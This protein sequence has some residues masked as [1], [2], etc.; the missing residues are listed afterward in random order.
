VVRR[1]NWLIAVAITL[2]ILCTA[3]ASFGAEQDASPTTDRR[4]SK[5]WMPAP[6]VAFNDP[7]GSD[8]G[9]DRLLRRIIEAVRHTHKGQT[10]R[11]AQYSFDRR[12]M[13]D[14]LIRAH[15]RGVNVQIIVND[16]WTSAPTNR[17]K[18]VLG[19][20]HHKDHFVVICH[21]SCRGGPGNLHLKV[22]S[23]TKTGGARDVIMTGSTNITNR[24]MSLQWNDMVTLR[25]K[26][27]LFDTWVKVFNQLKKD[28]AVRPR[29]VYFRS[30]S[31][32]ATFYRTSG[33][34]AE[35]KSTTTSRL[36]TADEDPVLKR[37]KRIRCNAKKG[38]G[39]NGH[40]VI[41]ITM[42]GWQD[43]RGKYLARRIAYLKRNG[44]DV[45]VILS[46]AGAG[47][48]ATLRRSHV[49][50]R[51]ADWDY[52]EE[53]KVNFYSHLKV[54]AV[55]GTFAHKRTHTVWTGSEN[56]STM[57]FRNDELTLQLNNTRIYRRYRDQFNSMWSGP[58][59]HRMGVRPTC[60]PLEWGGAD[61]CPGDDTTTTTS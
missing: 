28:K 29:W 6:G 56:W 5:H 30:D 21:G 25:G 19:T 43:Q 11:F 40:T 20:N 10:I 49:P 4:A 47:V 36:P 35:P 13:A 41:R 46:V 31:T 38:S 61:G 60:R 1:Q 53:G 34:T 8:D 39:I 33:E 42:Y 32:G 26:T 15:R 54:L 44:C 9:K 55:N 59:T 23:F 45:E 16:N 12:T 51:S 22:Y 50:M 48:K 18:R 7:I 17:L 3:T 52:N 58:E 57:S 2:G 37:L 24:A 14:A 27:K